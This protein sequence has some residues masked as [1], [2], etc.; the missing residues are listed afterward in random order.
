MSFLEKYRRATDARNSLVCVGL[1]PDP[2]RLPAHLSGTHDPVSAFLKDVISATCDL[3]CAYKPNFAFFGALGAAGWR[4]LED[5]LSAI[6]DATPVVLDFKANDIGNSARRYAQMAY[7]ALGVDAVTVNPLMGT[8]AVAPFMEYQDGCAFLLCLTS[9]PGSADFQRLSTQDGPFYQRVARK[10]V[11]WSRTGPCGLVVG[12]TH[13]RELSTVRRIAPGLPF[14]VPGVGAQMGDPG[15]VIRYGSDRNGK[16][17]L[18]NASRSVLYASSG[19][20]FA[21]AARCAAESLRVELERERA[22]SSS[23]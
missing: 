17:L 8:D 5:V 16:G 19:R 9:N 21:R 18:V 3:V 1:D 14:L 22:A 15:R 23:A 11:E 6:P 7:D 4:S 10:A 20:D 12:A 13:A 2:E